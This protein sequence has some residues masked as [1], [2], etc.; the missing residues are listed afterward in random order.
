MQTLIHEMRHA[1]QYSAMDHP[2]S[3]KVSKE[4]LTQWKNNF[5]NYRDADTFGYNSYVT[6]PIEYDAK[7]FAR[8]YSDVD[9]YK[10]DYG[11]SWG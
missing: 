1:Y 3:F 8:Q 11:G 6:Q 4:T 5:N 10:A 9:G 2:E 7:N